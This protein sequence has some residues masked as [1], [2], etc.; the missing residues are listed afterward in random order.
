[1][2]LVLSY[3]SLSSNYLTEIIKESNLPYCYSLSEGQILRADKIILPHPD[4]FDY[5][6]RHMQ[7]Y[8][9]FSALKLVKKPILGI[10]DGFRLMCNKIISKKRF[11]FGFFDLDCSNLIAENNV[12][13]FYSDRII[14]ETKSNLTNS[15][16]DDENFIFIP[17]N[18]T[19][20]NKYTKSNVSCMGYTFSVTKE[21]KNYFGVELDFIANKKIGNTIIK[22]FLKL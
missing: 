22:N 8:N 11:G 3:N 5:A 16:N 1:M 15:L 4:N 18:H 7:M 20:I 14:S 6:Y 17:N 21:N 9:L 13:D 2:V 10:N 19:R 12:P